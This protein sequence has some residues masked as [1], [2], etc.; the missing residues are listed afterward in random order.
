[1]TAPFGPA[2][3]E[4]GVRVVSV[5]ENNVVIRSTLLLFSLYWE[6]IGSLFEILVNMTRSMYCV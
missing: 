4:I 1:M 3:G 5:A 2:F 6:L